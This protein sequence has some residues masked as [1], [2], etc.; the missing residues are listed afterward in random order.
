ML[1]N[2]CI[3]IYTYI[4]SYI[5]INT[6]KA[7]NSIQVQHGTFYDVDSKIYS[8]LSSIEVNFLP[9]IATFLRLF[10]SVAEDAEDIFG[11]VNLVN[12][13]NPV[14]VKALTHAV[15]ATVAHTTARN[16]IAFLPQ[17]N[18]L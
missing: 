1:L 17:T 14:D 11:A 7:Q 15:K 13:V 8:L 4:Y 12:L 5:Y 10:L 3:Y 9:M 2:I 6:N 18:V 16:T